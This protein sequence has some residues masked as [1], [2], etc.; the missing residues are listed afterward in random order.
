MSIVKMRKMVRKQLKIRL[1]GRTIELGSPMAIT[2]WVFI[3]IFFVGTYYMYGGGGDGGGGPQ[4]AGPRTV[5][6]VV[7]RVDGHEITRHEYEARL[8]WAQSGR[9]APLT[10][11][12]QLKT[13]LLDA[14]IDNYLLLSAAHA[15]GIR[16]SNDEIEAKKN[17]MIEEIIEVRYADRRILREALERENMSLDEFKQRRLRDQLPDEETIRTNLLYEKLEEHVERNV[18]VTDED[19]RASFAEVNARHILIDPQRIMMEA[20]EEAAGEDGAEAAESETPMTFEQAELQ[21]RELMTEITQRLDDGEDFAT[22]AEEYSHCPSASDGGDLGWFGPGQMVP[23][24]EEVAFR[25]QPGELSD[26]V[27]TDFGL[28]VIKVEDRREDV[29]DDEALLSERREELMQQ[30]IQRAWQDYQERLRA[31]AEIEIVDPELKAYKLLEEDPQQNV[32]EAAELLA[33]AADSDPYNASARFTLASLLRQGGQNEEAIRVLRQLT[34]THE[35][36]NSPYV[37]MELATLMR[38]TGRDEQAIE[39]L[40]QASDFAQGF[41]FQNYFVHMQAQRIFEELERPDLAEREQEWIDDFMEH[42]AGGM[43]GV[44]P[45]EIETDDVAPAGDEE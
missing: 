28:H 40:Q 7:A 18:Q 33:A 38:E 36:S 17:E 29:P 1:F 30:R 25:L 14:I 10:E 11:Q 13:G 32:A 20:Q 5:T 4:Q 37:Q 19:L 2:L 21:A 9:S 45:I 27:E 39:H 34:E 23:A 8:A 15:E 3:V 16:V 31:A 43:G 12:R 42:Q 24:F 6:P 26:I 44:E 22:L 41:D 35:G